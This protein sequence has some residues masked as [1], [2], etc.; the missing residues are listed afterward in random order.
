MKAKDLITSGH[1]E[2]GTTPEGQNREATPPPAGTTAG[3]REG[4]PMGPRG[5]GGMPRRPQ[6]PPRMFEGPEADALKDIMLL[7][8]TEG[9]GNDYD[10]KIVRELMAGKDLDPGTL[11]HILD[12]GARLQNLPE[13]HIK[14]LEKIHAKLSS[15]A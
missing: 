12:E 7:F 1:L 3:G 5:M 9:A 6:G 10:G 13:S 4:R 8:L 2:E 15:G 11:Q 14:V